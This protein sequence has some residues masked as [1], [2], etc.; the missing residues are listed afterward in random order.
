[1]AKRFVHIRKMVYTIK[2]IIPDKM[3]VRRLKDEICPLFYLLC[4]DFSAI[5]F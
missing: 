3:H 4:G 5:F 1:M 2:S